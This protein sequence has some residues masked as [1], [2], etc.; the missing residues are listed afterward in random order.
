MQINGKWHNYLEDENS[1]NIRTVLQACITAERLCRVIACLLMKSRE[2]RKLC[3]TSV[4]PSFDQPITNK[5]KISSLIHSYSSIR[6][7]III[8]GIKETNSSTHTNHTTRWQT[9]AYWSLLWRTCFYNIFK[10]A[11]VEA[12]HNDTAKFKVLRTPCSLP[13]FCSQ[14]MLRATT[15]P[16]HCGSVAN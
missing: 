1:L 6:K 10:A 7:L 14:W 2:N 15:C 9:G 16:G 5:I 13:S 8:D 11:S 12:Q 4:R 3:T